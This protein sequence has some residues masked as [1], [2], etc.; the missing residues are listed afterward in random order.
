[1]RRFIFSLIIWGSL[2]HQSY[3]MNE[4]R[5]NDEDSGIKVSFY[6][7]LDEYEQDEGYVMARSLLEIC[8]QGSDLEEWGCLNVIYYLLRDLFGPERVD[9][10]NFLRLH[11]KSYSN[12]GVCIDELNKMLDFSP[13]ER[14]AFCKK[15]QAKL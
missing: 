10:L 15:N 9:F 1:M 7:H 3:A 11:V 13:Y 8:P 14:L 12:L 6:L 2:F 5:F 4:D